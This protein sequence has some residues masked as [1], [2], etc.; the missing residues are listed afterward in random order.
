MT[1]FDKLVKKILVKQKNA[2]V[3][4][5]VSESLTQSRS[6]AFKQV[7]VSQIYTLEFIRW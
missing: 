4:V 2:N 5:S 3:Q 7:S 1:V 6:R